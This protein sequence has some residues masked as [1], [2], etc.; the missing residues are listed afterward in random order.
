[1]AQSDRSLSSR[2]ASQCVLLWLAGKSWND[3]HVPAKHKRLFWLIQTEAG[4]VNEWESGE[5]CFRVTVLFIWEG[6]PCIVCDFRIQTKDN[7]CS[8]T[9]RLVFSRRA[10]AA[11]RILKPFPAQTM[12][13][14]KWAGYD[15]HQK[16]FRNRCHFPQTSV[17]WWWSSYEGF[18]FISLVN[19]QRFFFSC[20]E[21]QP[22]FMIYVFELH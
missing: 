9:S 14:R 1:M 6:T 12:N 11:G 8:Q 13:E 15:F 10:R 21:Q 7:S 22:T 17:L 5:G 4:H 16:S 19:L 3:Q 18:V 2:H 20:A